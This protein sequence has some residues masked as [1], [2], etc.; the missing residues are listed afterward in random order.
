ML[1]N[2]MKLAE[3][4]KQ[5]KEST[6]KISD[7]K[8]IV[9]AIKKIRSLGISNPF[10]PGETIIDDNV[11]LEV[12]KFDGALWI[13]SISTMERSKGDASKVLK[14]VCDIA[15][16]YNV[17]IRM[18]PE[19]YGNKG[20]TK[21]Q[22]I[23]WYKRYGFKNISWGEMERLPIVKEIIL[24]ESKQVGLV[25]HFTTVSSLIDILNQ[26]KIKAYDSSRLQR[27]TIST[28]RNKNFFKQRF[29]KG[30][31]RK[32]FSGNHVAL[33]LDG[34]KLSTQFQTKP[35]FDAITAKERESWGDEMEQIWFGTKIE[36]YNGIPNIHKYV[37]KI[38][39]I[40]KM[41]ENLLNNSFLPSEFEVFLIKK[42]STKEKYKKYLDLPIEKKVSFFIHF[43]KTI[44]NIE[45]ELQ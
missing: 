25:Y 5:L 14:K 33:E 45:I 28:T 20:L 42:F 27:P 1:N 23:R 37:T 34:T 4:Y 35:H 29:A 31:Y 39:L 32:P 43:L 8:D 9:A 13:S 12:T 3:I 38:I 6:Y 40:K 15:D 10:L 26:D 21:N 41:I 17:I 16:E 11:K 19:P 30:D 2:G 44:T 7:E 24:K 18:S 22:L 36:Q